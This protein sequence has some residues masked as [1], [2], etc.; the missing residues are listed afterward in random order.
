MSRITPPVP[1]TTL[2]PAYSSVSS[3]AGFQSGDLVYFRD[4]NFGTIPGNAVTSANFPIN[5]DVTQ[6]Q[7]AFNATV[8]WANYNPNTRTGS[9]NTRATSAATL[10]NGNIVV[11]YGEHLSSG[12]SPAYFKIIDQ[13][14]AIVVDRTQIGSL[15]IS[16]QGLIGV[17]AL[18]GGGFAVAFRNTTSDGIAHGVYS[19]TGAVV[20]AIAQDATLGTGFGT[21]EIRALSGGGYV[22][23]TQVSSNYRFRVFSSVGVGGTSSTVSGWNSD[24]QI[25]VTTFS[26]NTFAALYPVGS[27]SLSISRFDNTGGF[28]ATYSVQSDWSSSTGYDFI[29]LS[30]GLGIVLS[31]DSSSFFAAVRTYNQSTGAVSGVVTNLEAF[32]QTVNGYALS[33]GGYVAT[34]CVPSTGTVI[35][36]RLSAASAVVS[37]VELVGLPG[38]FAATQAGRNQRITI[39]E[40]ST[41]LT[42]IDNSYV[43]TGYTYHSMP[44]IQV[45]KTNVT[46]TGI[47]RRFA[48]NSSVG[49]VSAAVSGYARSASTP[50]SAS[51]LAATTQTLTLNVP[52]SSGSTFVLAPYTAIGG[53]NINSMALTDMTNGQF[54][55]AYRNTLNV[56]SFSVF[57]PS[58]T[59]I[60]TTTV[61]T[62]AAAQLVRCTCLGN[63]KLVVSWCTNSSTVNFAVYAANT[64][65]L[66]ATGVSAGGGFSDVGSWNSSAGHDIAPFGNDSFVVGINNNSNGSVCV[67]VYDDSAVFQALVNGDAFGG[68]QNIRIASDAA[69]DVAIRHYA[70]SQSTGY[71]QYF[72]RNATTNSLYFFQVSSVNSSGYS[73]QNYGEGCVMTPYGTVVGA[74]SAGGSRRVAKSTPGGGNLT[75][76]IGSVDYNAANPCVGQNGEVVMIRID[77]SPAWYRYS[78]SASQFAAGGNVAP[79]SNVSIDGT[80][81][82]ITGQNTNTTCGSQAQI[83]NLYDNIYAF[84]F[85]DGGSNSSGSIRVGLLCTVASTYTT[86][87]TA[88]VTASNTALI[89]SPSNGYCLAGVS[90]SECAA[91]GTGVLQVNGAAT[92]NSQYPAGTTSQ[93]FDFNTPALDVGIRGTISGRNVILS[94]GK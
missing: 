68:N 61:A 62:N 37:S 58:G 88:G 46:A 65:V 90:A 3:T 63:G 60:S 67:L 34:T 22:I 16:N 74:T 94:G 56:V 51:F 21:L 13:S 73:T 44:Y 66:L 7:I 32:Q 11:V 81:L 53:G 18:T 36:R 40:G 75:T 54:V 79:N 6:N 55:I 49:A 27:S 59:L 5:A 57:N 10:T 4:S 24:S 2:T 69:G 8:N 48:A 15:N 41:F 71:T 91:G 76:A 45:N 93:A 12:G 28:V 39:L 29:T 92:L 85:I 1:N 38:Y 72:T 17:C 70:T 77:G 25:V 83:V 33:G 80:G 9:T 31:I 82:T 30:T 52:V 47:R 26:D 43:S 23:A 64:Y 84:A 20:T 50:N 78:P 19:N 42:L 86:N 87:I 35:L 14:G 89:P